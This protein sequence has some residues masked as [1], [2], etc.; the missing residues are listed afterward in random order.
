MN[1]V[2]KIS[3]LSA[4]LL[5]AGAVSMPSDAVLAKEIVLGA[6]VQLMGPVANTGRYYRDAYQLAVDR[7]NAAG[8]VKVGNESYKLALKLYDNQSDVNFNLAL[9][10]A[11]RGYVMESGRIARS[12]SAKQLIDDPEVRLLI[13]GFE[14]SACDRTT[15]S[16]GVDSM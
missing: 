5:V 9:S 16:R 2:F 15:V 13:S 11:D 6:S 7:I 4:L 10:V 14:T 12:G 1:P 8:G 3:R